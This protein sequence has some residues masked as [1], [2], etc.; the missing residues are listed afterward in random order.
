MTLQTIVAV[1]AQL[2]E[3]FHG[4]EKVRGSNPRNGSS[5][6]SGFRLRRIRS[7]DL[8]NP[9]NGSWLI[10]KTSDMS[11]DNMIKLECS[12]CKRIN[13]FSTKNK[14]MLKN[15]LEMG[16]FCKHCKKHTPHKETK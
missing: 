9:D 2:V 16:K 10:N 15:R 12:V 4:K 3:H 14:K 11:Q 7:N 8:T 5:R 1:V 6:A 13:Y